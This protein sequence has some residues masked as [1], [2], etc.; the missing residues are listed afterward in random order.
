MKN[1]YPILVI[2]TIFCLLGCIKN[3]S[4]LTNSE[5]PIYSI[6]D[7]GPA[8]GIIFYIDKSNE[9]KW[10]F[11]EAAPHGWFGEWYGTF[12][13][14][15]LAWGNVGTFSNIIKTEIGSGKENTKKLLESDY[16]SSEDDLPNAIQAV[17]NYST[18]NKG[19]IYDDWFLPALNELEAMYQTLWKFD[20]GKLDN[21]GYWTSS[22]ISGFSAWLVDFSR[23]NTKIESKYIRHNIRPV[24][25]F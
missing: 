2:L 14:P 6:G 9:F 24:R 16:F 5:F 10:N 15:E 18:T 7:H 13:D 3:K 19:I 8:G 11:L 22:E 25:S 20:I 4:N 12:N 21:N 1:F 23:T 17:H